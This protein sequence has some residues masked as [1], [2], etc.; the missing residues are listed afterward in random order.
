MYVCIIL[1]SWKLQKR[2]CG[3]DTYHN[4]AYCWDSDLI[5]RLTQSFV[6][7]LPQNILLPFRS[8]PN[9]ACLGHPP[10]CWYICTQRI[11]FNI[12]CVKNANSQIGFDTHSMLI[13]LLQ[14][15]FYVV[16]LRLYFMPQTSR[17]HHS[18]HQTTTPP[19]FESSR[20]LNHAFS[21]LT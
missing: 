1:A 4:S 9:N 6:L 20:G 17:C 5:A 14:Y 18:M 16:V 10:A 11:R 7:C 2:G 12:L 21:R 8:G 15:S 3:D 19:H 13:N